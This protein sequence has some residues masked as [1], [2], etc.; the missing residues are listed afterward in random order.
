MHM[1]QLLRPKTL[2]SSP[3]FVNSQLSLPLDF[4]CFSR[5]A[6]EPQAPSCAEAQSNNLSELL[7]VSQSLREWPPVCLMVFRGAYEP[8]ARFCAKAIEVAGGRLRILYYYYY[9]YYYY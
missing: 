8:Q 5:G 2:R 7:R 3:P 6:Y 1:L 9:Y 4:C